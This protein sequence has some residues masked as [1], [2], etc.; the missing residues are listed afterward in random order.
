MKSPKRLSGEAGYSL[1][2]MI[3]VLTLMALVGAVLT[4]TLH[5]REAS[6]RDVARQVA[7]AARTAAARAIATGRSSVL[8]V[9]LAGRS[10]GIDQ[11]PA[12]ARIPASYSVFMTA[13]E[14][15]VNAKGTGTIEF[16]P[17]GSST[18][19]EVTVGAPNSGQFVV[20]VFWLTGEISTRRAP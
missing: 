4:M 14:H 8:H 1:L 17:D 2:E 10:I 7:G 15:P 12:I 13:A 16:F 18:G 11:D 6:P 19:G 3:I 20:R 5:R 9:D